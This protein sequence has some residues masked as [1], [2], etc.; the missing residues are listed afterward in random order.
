MMLG[1]QNM[2]GVSKAMALYLPFVLATS[3]QLPHTV[4][5]MHMAS[6]GVMLGGRLTWAAFFWKCILPILLGNFVG[7]ALIMGLYHWYVFL[8]MKNGHVKGDTFQ[9]RVDE[10]RD[11]DD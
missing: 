10:Y 1:T 8:V 11:D 6:L 5:Y 2:D 9:E 4:E 7:G 3:T